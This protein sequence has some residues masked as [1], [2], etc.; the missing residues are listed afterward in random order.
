MLPGILFGF[1][2]SNEQYV[3]PLVWKWPIYGHMDES[4]TICLEGQTTV[5][6]PKSKPTH[7]NCPRNSLDE[8]DLSNTSV[9]K[10]KSI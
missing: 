3:H 8:F 2:H 1:I 10:K 5:G 4:A 7:L 9:K 6:T